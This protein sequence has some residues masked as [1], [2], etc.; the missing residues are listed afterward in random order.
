[1]KCPDCQFENRE[2]VKFC[3]ECGA[4]MEM[5]CPRCGCKVLPGRK[6]CG[7]CGQKLT[8]M[9]TAR[10][11]EPALEVEHKGTEPLP[12]AERKMTTILFSDMSGFTAMNE[13]L[14]P[15][16]VKEIMGRIFDGI[17][18]VVTKYDG[19]IDKF[20]GDAVMAL[21][22]VPQA[23]ED[24]PVRAIRAA[25][26]IHELVAGMSPEVESRTGRPLSMHSGV[27]TGLVVT[28]TLEV[29]KGLLGFTGDAINLAARLS[30]L[31]EHDQVLV[32]PDTYALARG[33]FDFE[34]LQPTE[35]KGKAEPVRVYKV[36]ALKEQAH[37]PA[38]VRSIHIGRKA[39]IARLQEA[40]QQL[41]EGRGSVVSVWGPAGTGKT[42]LVEEFKSGLDVEAIQ[43]H[44]GRAYAYCQKIPYFPLIDLLSR[45]M[46]VEEGDAPEKV[47]EKVE[48]ALNALVGC[49]ANVVPYIGSLYSLSY[50]EIEEVSPEFWKSQLQAAVGTVLTALAERNP[51]VVCVEDLHWA[52]SSTVELIRFLLTELRAPV[53]FICAYRPPFTLF[54]SHQ[55]GLLS[56]PYHEIILQDLSASDTQE[57]VASLL[58]TEDVPPELSHFVQAKVEGNPFYL[59]EFINALIDAQILVR[60]NGGWSLTRPLVEADVPSTIHGVIS[61]RLDRLEKENKRILQEASVIGR[62]FFYELLKSISD[63]HDRAEQCLM[64]LVRLDIIRTRAVQPDVEYMF[65]HALTQEVAYSGLLKKDRQVIHERI[66]RVMEKLFQDRLPEFHEALAFHF[67]RGRSMLKAV[68]YLMKSGEKSLK[69]YAVEESHQFYQEAFD[70]LSGKQDLT[71]EEKGLLIDLLCQWAFVYY[72]RGDFKG[73]IEILRAHLPLAEALGDKARLGIFYAWYG[74]SLNCRV[75]VR[76]SYKYLRLGLE[77]AEEVHDHKTIGLASAWLA[78]TCNPLGLFDEALAFG[79][80]AEE[81]SRAFPT[82]QYLF[83]KYMGGIGFTNW[84]QGYAGRAVEIGNLILEFGQKHSNVRSI[85]MGHYIKGCGYMA[86]GDFST[87]VEC[88]TKAVE[89]AADPFYTQFSRLVL[90]LAYLMNQQYQEAEEA[91][92]QVSSYSREYGAEIIGAPAD[93]ILGSDLVVKGQMSQGVRKLE[94]LSRWCLEKGVKCYY[95]IAELMLGT[96]YTQI[97]LGESEVSPMTMLKNIGFIIKNVPSAPK[98]A[99]EH[100]SRVIETA[101]EIGSPGYIGAAKLALGRVY[102]AKKRND[103]A[104]ETL[105]EAAALF[106]ECKAKTMLKQARDEMAALP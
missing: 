97:V 85:T 3:E 30:N 34:A 58:G 9:I 48:G 61:A 89:A 4:K 70:L 76:D 80:R 32:G 29:E 10:G 93:F 25:R 38:G 44:E 91:A 57:M 68:D 42:R 65:K 84:N 49:G 54:S 105:T 59:E 39:E 94:E 63:V 62:A 46:Q 37:R 6:F 67:K 50:P 27:N 43:W 86:D 90:G 40:A 14:D 20:I 98:K 96:I 95:V 99:E 18:R 26:E 83:F 79:Q 75:E 45:A 1:M 53:L 106:E 21:F 47:R 55:A 36:L 7:E 15:E 16:E 82:D 100:F 72:Y 5:Q 31:A 33:Y 77:L 78:W 64:N 102:K 74:F 56:L 41:M 51:T 23:H 69:R 2:G 88:L 12:E 73:L 24:D 11:A 60:E 28:G 52:D 87:A 92:E 22:G 104:R 66:G 71:K 81:I 19:V 13:K 35:V 101:T 103:R 17:S 8:E